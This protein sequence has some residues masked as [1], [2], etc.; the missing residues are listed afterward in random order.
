M[1]AITRGSKMIL[2][3]TGHRPE[4]LKGQEKMIKEW[5][6]E[7]LTRLQP[8][9]VYD[10]MAQGTD[11]IVAIAAKELDIPIVCCYAFPRCGYHPVE[12]WIM[13]GNQV[14]FICNEYSKQAYWL[15][16][17]FMV[18]AAD[19]VLT[20]WDGKGGGGT[21]ITRNYALQQGKKIIDY[22][23]LRKG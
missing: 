21:F 12:E 15:R 11:Q 23:G 8:S 16:D 10:G 14:R 20:V 1:A 22:V 19:V 18:D 13:E 6:V 4:R 2:T 9:V 17:K 7:Q 3:V 5:A